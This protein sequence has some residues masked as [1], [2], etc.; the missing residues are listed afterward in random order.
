[1]S[2]KQSM[3]PEGLIK[4]NAALKAHIERNRV[5]AVIA[6][7]HLTT[8][9]AHDEE[10]AFRALVE[11]LTSTPAQSLEQRDHEIIDKCAALAAGYYIEGSIMHE[12][13]K[14]LVRAIL[15]LKEG[16]L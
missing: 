8:T 4:E 9:S 16:K 5:L 14:G 12:D 6:R 15:K 3:T 13:T 11:I 1:M 2:D 7:N 10:A